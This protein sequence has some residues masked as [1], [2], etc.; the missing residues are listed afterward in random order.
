MKK[1]KYIISTVLIF[2]LSCVLSIV[3]N[4]AGKVYTEADGI[5]TV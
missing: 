5:R 1:I 2:V 3:A 4:A